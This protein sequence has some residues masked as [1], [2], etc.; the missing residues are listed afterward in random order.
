MASKTD[1]RRMVLLELKVIAHVTQAPS[2]TQAQTCDLWIDAGRAMLLEA[3]LCWWDEDDIPQSVMI[4]VSKYIASQ[5]CGAFGKDGKGHEAKEP[6]ALVK[7]AEL[8]PSAHRET[9]R[10]DYF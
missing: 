6:L 8:K 1:L 4:P 10:A 9:T 2:Q 3:G 5:C 7:L